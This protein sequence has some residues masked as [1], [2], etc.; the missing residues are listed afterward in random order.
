MSA[1]PAKLSLVQHGD[2]SADATYNP[3]S[4]TDIAYVEIFPPVGIAR[5]GDSEN[6]YFLAP[7]VPGRTSPPAGID[8]FRDSEQKIR[9]QAVR[10]RVYAYDENNNNLG[11]INSK[12]VIGPA[13]QE[14]YTLQWTVHVANKKAAHTAFQG[15]YAQPPVTSLRNPNVQ[16]DLDLD[17]REKLIVDPKQQPISQASTDFVNLKDKFQGSNKQG[18]DINE[19]YHQVHWDDLDKSELNVDP[20]QQ[21][22]S[23]ASTDFVNLKG[24]FQGSNKQVT[25]DINDVYLGQLQVDQAG[26]LIFVPGTGNAKCV[27][28]PNNF[29][30]EIVS[31]FDSADWI[32]TACDGWVKVEVGTSQDPSSIT[33]IIPLKHTATVIT[34]PPKFVW[35]INSPT[36]LYNIMEDLYWRGGQS[37]W[38]DK[39]VVFDFLKDIWPVLNSAASISWTNNSALQGHGP[40][41]NGHFSSKKVLEIFQKGSTKEKNDLKT[42][43]FEK[44]RKPD[45]EDP[46]QA[47][48]R[49]MPRLSGDNGDMPDPGQFPSGLQP[50]IKRFAALTKL[51]YERFRKWKD[52]TAFTLSDHWSP[53]PQQEKIEDLTKED[54]PEYLTRASLETTIG[55]PLFP[56]IETYWFAK[57]SSTYDF[58]VTNL[59]PPFRVNQQVQPGYFTRGLSLPWQCDFELCATHWWPSVRPDDVVPKAAYDNIMG[60]SGTPE[61]FDTATTTRRAWT[62][63]FRDTLDMGQ[64]RTSTDIPWFASTDMV[65]YW[66]HLGIIRKHEKTYPNEAGTI[67]AY[68]ESERL[69]L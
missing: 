47:D 1:E 31:E 25:P 23:Q 32:D 34:A 55:D 42:R 64:S 57:L 43:I 40:S 20:K 67:T 59:D 11:E 48:G 52:D 39:P 54:Q 5:F 29:Q 8:K 69:D 15:R 41:S 24:I 3:I 65:R 61:Q 38:P 46:S 12:V 68:V 58:T 37:D 26:R 33:K 45:Y 14:H 21:P 28:D 50:D 63:G 2:P 22:I 17:K 51:Q 16:P 7:E 10:F 60:K 4:L 27:A 66:N 13:A 56:G 44:L 18:T 35:G 9:R 36:T 53:E 30:P 62:R 19:V 49:Y 6:E